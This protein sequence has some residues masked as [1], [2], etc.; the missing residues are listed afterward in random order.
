PMDISR[1]EHYYRAA[2]ERIGQAQH[3][4]HEGRS[5]ALAMYAAGV[6]VECMLRAFRARKTFEFESRHDLLALFAE[7]GMLRVGQEMLKAQGWS[8]HDI[9][10]HQVT[11]R[12]AVNDVYSLWHNNYRYASEERLLAHLKRM[13]LYQGTKGNLLKAKSL[14][15][16]RAA[17]LF[18]DR[19]VLQ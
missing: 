16:L 17:K 19:G 6:A 1:P 10:N 5:F 13:K 3:L 14:Q 11:L 4:Y 18:V 12:T 2:L 8:D 15:L 9:T 7:S